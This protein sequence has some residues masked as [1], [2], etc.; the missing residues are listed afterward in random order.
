MARL[1][2]LMRTLIELSNSKRRIQLEELGSDLRN[3]KLRYI[4]VIKKWIKG[5]R[6]YLIEVQPIS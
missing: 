3:G 1:Q 2:K 5:E 4:N 6:A